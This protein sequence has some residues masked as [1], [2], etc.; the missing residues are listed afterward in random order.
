MNTG[1]ELGQA[2]IHQFNG[3]LFA[4][5]THIESLKLPNRLFV[6][7]GQAR[8]DAMVAEHKDTL[9][10]LSAT[11]NFASEG[12]ARNSIGLYTLGHIFEQSIVELEKLE[13]DAEGRQRWPGKTGQWDKWIF[14]LTAAIVPHDRRSDEQT[15][16]PEPQP[17]IQGEG[18]IGC[19]E[20]RED[21]GRVGAAV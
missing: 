11:Y 15:T 10:F 3:G 20:G 14:C 12:D 7:Y 1:G 9:L 16:P 8:N 13:A 6:R 21:A 5:D 18:G 17:G 4:D 2:T 19:R